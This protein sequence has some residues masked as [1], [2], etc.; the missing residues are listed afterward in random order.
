MSNSQGDAICSQW[1]SAIIDT[2]HRNKEHADQ[3]IAQLSEEKL[4]LSLDAET[5]SVAVIMKHIAGNL[6]SRWLD[7]LEADG[8]KL[9]RERDQEF[10]DDYA[11]REEILG[12]WE[13][14]WQVLFDELEKLQPGD[15]LREITIRGHQI[16]VPHA[17]T[18]PMS[19]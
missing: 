3:A 10:I 12:D 5:N 11:G 7:F 6:R 14:G 8:E 16:S 4:R 1:L 9:N 19:H 15:L 18:R 17:I 2:F 13:A